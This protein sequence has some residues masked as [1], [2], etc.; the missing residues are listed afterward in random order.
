MIVYMALRT[1]G[2]PGVALSVCPK[3]QE[4][5][6]T[7]PRKPDVRNVASS[8]VQYHGWHLRSSSDC[9]ALL[10]PP[11]EGLKFLGAQAL[12]VFSWPSEGSGFW[13]LGL[14]VVQGRVE[15]CLK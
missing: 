2:L 8:T 10:N 5:L 13:L 3:K 9:Y 12:I 6:Q 1:L 4:E 11:A 7:P 15:G 14:V